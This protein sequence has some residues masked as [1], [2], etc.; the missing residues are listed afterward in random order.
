MAPR[1]QTSLVYFRGFIQSPAPAC[2][3]QA[4]QVSCWIN[5]PH[6][7]HVSRMSSKAPGLVTSLF[8]PGG[9]LKE[10]CR[11]FDLYKRK[12]F[13]GS[14]TSFNS[15]TVTANRFRGEERSQRFTIKN[16]RNQW[17][18]MLPPK[19]RGRAKWRRSAT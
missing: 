17:D 19:G 15:A 10:K 11:M 9:L 18:A 12:R 5:A 6:T 14:Y 2:G 3:I 8:E 13:L 16:K 7:S 4:R 1:K